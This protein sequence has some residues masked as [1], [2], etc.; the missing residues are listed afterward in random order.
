MFVSVLEP[1]TALRLPSCLELRVS[2]QSLR[3]YACLSLRFT[4]QAG[5]PASPYSGVPV[6]ST[7]AHSF[8]R[9]DLVEFGPDTDLAGSPVH[10]VLNHSRNVQA[11]RTALRSIASHRALPAPSGFAREGPEGGRSAAH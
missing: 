7:L 2:K 1:L 10:N 11:S 4:V 8:S 3:L 6:T 5:D 9:D